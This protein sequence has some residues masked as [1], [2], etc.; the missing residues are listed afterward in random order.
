MKIRGILLVTLT[1][2]TLIIDS[3]SG[4]LK[5][6]CSDLFISEYV[7]G[8]SNNKAIE[9]Y[10]PTSSPINMN[11]YTL[12]RFRNQNST[13]TNP[14][15]LV[16]TIQPYDVYVVVLDKRDSLGT[17]F[18]APVWDSLQAKADTFCNPL[19]NSGAEAMYF[20][21]NDPMA[22]LK[23]GGA[24]IVD[25]FGKISDLANPDGWG[26]YGIDSIGN[27]L[28]VSKDHTLIRKSGIQTG[29]TSPPSTFDPYIE[30]DSLPANTFSSL[31]SHTC[32]CS[33]GPGV[34]FYNISE[35]NGI[36]GTGVDDS[37]G[38]YCELRGVV[39]GYNVRPSGLH[40][41]LIDPTGSIVVFKSTGNVGYMVQETD[42]IRVWGTLSQ[43]FGL[44][45]LVADSIVLVSTGK[46]LKSP[47]I[48][49]TIN[50][51]LESDLIKFENAW[52]VTPSQWT[53]LSPG[54]NVDITDGTNIM[55]MRIDADVDIF[56]T[57]APMDT[58]H[59]TGLAGQ[60]DSL[61][62]YLD[63][64]NIRPRYLADIQTV[65]SCGVTSSLAQ[66]VSG[67]C[68]GS[69]IAFTSTSTGATSY[70]WLQNGV[71]FASGT[72][73]TV[74]QFFPTAGSYTITLI[75]SNGGCSD[76]STTAVT[77]NS[78]PT[79]SVTANGP[80]TFCTGDSVVLVATSGTA[81]LYE[82]STGAFGTS[83]TVSTSGS[84]SV[85][86]TDFSNCTGVSSA[87]TV[88][89]TNGLNPT[90]TANGPTSFCP[91]GSVTLSASVGA[92]YLWSTGATTQE[93]TVSA[94][95][96]YTVTVTDGTGCSGTSAPTTISITTGLTPTI[97]ASGPTTFCQGGS[98]SLSA[99]TGATYL[100]STGETGKDTTVSAAGSYTV[101]VT[102]G[103]GCSGTS[104]ATTVSVMASP[105][106]SLVTSTDASSCGVSDGT[107]N[108]TASGGTAP[109]Q[110]SIDAGVTFSATNGFSGL[111][112]G[113]YDIV[114]TDASG[115]EVSGGTEIISA[116]GAPT[117]SAG[118]DGTVCTDG[119]YTLSGSMGG[120]ASSITWTSSGSGSFDDAS[121]LT[122]SY[123]PSAADILAGTVTLTITS[124]D[125][126]GGGPCQPA[127]DNLVLTISSGPATPTISQSGNTL[128]SSSATTYQWF[129]NG[130]S[131]VGETGQFYT[132]TATGFYSV[133]VGDAFG[134]TTSSSTVN[135]ILGIVEMQLGDVDIYPNPSTGLFT[136]EFASMSDSGFEI[137]VL[138]VLGKR[139]F[140]AFGYNNSMITTIDL[141]EYPSGLYF[142][143]VRKEN[144]FLVRKIVKN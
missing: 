74:T 124:D 38:V 142:V 56:G 129:M 11:G 41:G 57:A 26:F 76:S 93:I 77:I 50:E 112:T 140:T 39:Y 85:T 84:Y 7:E 65:V 55:E 118:T 3:R 19:Y 81:I 92:T 75:A 114:V 138:D 72:A 117:A 106:V 68:A 59:V 1:L 83:I 40:F 132:A 143:Q 127:V 54:F 18:E 134:C 137:D 25:I 49:T 52:L 133:T 91:G 130:D 78:V 101:T 29:V 97:T 87:I 22:I 102:D 144:R 86:V 60:F 89:V 53:N 139:M 141:R 103:V 20:N 4:L 110:Y 69:S 2:V 63:S 71:S 90:I 100:W 9:I 111:S 82:W 24:T 94:A 51:G 8:W 135:L 43:Y 14:I 6:Q 98:V 10:N 16:G 42:T 126:D 108:I 66:T 23:N 58:F 125:P 13:P 79:V 48:T 67:V 34:P 37:I 45:E 64:Y 96:S 131:I 95:G 32:D 35:I 62:P 128:Q 31:G 61:S 119:T 80:T 17:G 15:N 113:N 107:I 123:T 109:L 36:N 70:I 21:G 30:W 12:V 121:S 136:I 88:V 47:T 27:S 122:A 46:T 105:V 104:T 28:Y 33:V 99:S 116:P 5:A 73:T 120:T 115:C 44:T